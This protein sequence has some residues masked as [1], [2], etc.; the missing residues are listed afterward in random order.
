MKGLLLFLL[1]TTCTLNAASFYWVGGSGDWNDVTHWAA[2]SGGATLYANTPSPN[3]D[4]FIDENS[5][6]GPNQTIDLLD[7]DVQMRDLVITTSQAGATLTGGR[8]GMMSVYGNLQLGTNVSWGYEAPI[9]LRG[10]RPD[11]TVNTGGR[12]I[13][14][15]ITFSGAATSNWLVEADVTTDGVFRFQSGNLSFAPNTT[16]TARAASFSDD[17]S[18]DYTGLSLVV[19]QDVRLEMNA[20]DVPSLASCSVTI[21]ASSFVTLSVTGVPTV[22]LASIGYANS[23][24][25]T[26]LWLG[27][28]GTEIAADRIELAGNVEHRGDS[29]ATT[30]V[31]APGTIHQFRNEVTL[32]VT[33]ALEATAPC[34][35]PIQL[36]AGELASVNAPASATINA[37]GLFIENVTATGGADFTATESTGV[38]TVTGWNFTDTQPDRYWVGG[39]G[40]WDDP[41][42]WSLTSGGPAGACPPT[43]L[44]DV[45][46]DAASF[47][48]PGQTVTIPAGRFGARTMDWRGND[49]PANIFSARDAVLQLYG[50]LFLAENVTWGTERDGAELLF[51][52]G[53]TNKRVAGKG[54]TGRL[55]VS[56][57]GTTGEW[58]LIDS[59]PVSKNLTLISGAL[60]TNDQPISGGD[61]GM[62]R[63]GCNLDLTNSTVYIRDYGAFIL[64]ANTSVTL[65]GGSEGNTFNS[66]GATIISQN[67]NSAV[68]ITFEGDAANPNHLKALLGEGY[69]ALEARDFYAET[70]DLQLGGELLIDGRVDD[71]LL[72]GGSVYSFG[73]RHTRLLD[74]GRFV[75][76][77]D[78][79]NQAIL[80]GIDGP[81]T[82]TSPTAQTG[83]F[84]GIENIAAAGGPWGAVSSNDFGG[85]TGWNFTSSPTARTLYWVGNGGDWRDPTHWS[86]SSGGPGGEC[87]PG[88]L[89]DVVFDAASFSSPG[90]AVLLAPENSTEPVF[91]RTIET[92]GLVEPMSFQ[93][94]SMEA[95]GSAY[96]SS[97]VRFGE[98]SFLREVE[99][100]RF[101]GTGREAFFSE[102]VDF[103]KMTVGGGGQLDLLAPF[104]GGFLRVVNGTFRTND[105]DL[106]LFN[107]FSSAPRLDESAVATLDMGTTTA[108]LSGSGIAFSLGGNDRSLVPNDGA[109]IILTNDPLIY[110]NPYVEKLN[111]T[112]AEGT[113][114]HRIDLREPLG[115]TPAG[116][117]ARLG[118]VT[119]N[120]SVTISAS[121][122]A[123]TLLL[124]PGFTYAIDG[125]AD[126][127]I[128]DRLIAVGTACNPVAVEQT[129]GGAQPRINF[130]PGAVAEMDYVRLDRVDATGPGVYQAG[131]N[132]V[133]VND[134]STGWAFTTNAVVQS[135]DREFLGPDPTGCSPPVLV[136]AVPDDFVATYR[137]RGGSTRPEFTPPG[138][139]TYGLT[140]TFGED[141]CRVADQ[142]TIGQSDLALEAG[143][144]ID[145]CGKSTVELVVPDPS[146][147][148]YTWRVLDGAAVGTPTATAIT[149]AVPAVVELSQTV[150]G[151]TGTSRYNVTGGV[152]IEV[153]TLVSLCP[154]DSYTTERGTYTP[155]D[156]EVITEVYSEEGRCDSTRNITFAV[157][158]AA[159]AVQLVQQCVNRT[160]TISGQDYIASQDTLITVGLIG[161]ARCDNVQA[162]EVTVILPLR[163]TTILADYTAGDFTT[164]RQTY[165]FA[166]DTIIEERYTS[167]STGC[168]SLH[169]YV[170]SRRSVVAV[171]TEVSLCGPA[172]FAARSQTYFVTRDTIITERN[173]GPGGRDTLQTYQ[174]SVG[175]GVQ[176]G[177]TTAEVC[178]GAFITEERGYFITR[179]T[180]FSETYR[181][182]DGCDSIHTYVLSLSS[183]VMTTSTAVICGAAPFVTGRA[184]YFV[185]R[186][187]VIS[188][189]YRS[190][191]DCD[192][193]VNYSVTVANNEPVVGTVNV[194]DVDCFDPA[195]GT[196]TVIGTGEFSAAALT[197]NGLAIPFN[198]TA[199]GLAA[200]DYLLAITYPNGC[201]ENRGLQITSERR[202]IESFAPIYDECGVAS[203]PL[204]TGTIRVTR[205]TL[206]RDTIVTPTGCSEVT[207]YDVDLLEIP[208]LPALVTTTDVSCFGA[209][210]GTLSVINDY[211]F[212]RLEVNGVVVT[213]DSLLT[214]LPPGS[215]EVAAYYCDDLTEVSENLTVFIIEPEP[216]LVSLPDAPTVLSGERI[217][218][219]AEV[220]G[221]VGLPSFTYAVNDTSADAR[222][223]DCPTIDLGL[224]V[225]ARVAVTA[226]DA[227]GCVA[228]DSTLV[229]VVQQ[230]RA[231]LPTAFS[232]NGDGVN[233]RL[234]VYGAGTGAGVLQLLEVYDRWGG[235]V[236]HRENIPIGDPESGWGGDELPA[237]SY[238]V[239]YLIMWP[240]G[241][242]TNR[243]GAVNLL[244]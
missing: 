33:G 80:R 242:V 19:R 223:I 201:V 43:P 176:T 15:E 148:G 55:D 7:L 138:P 44:N 233:D 151:C 27:R 240:D 124:A 126:L 38:N 197:L 153:D 125:R 62:G 235:V 20:A 115:G 34:T 150:N 195:S 217:E 130:R 118:T 29:R 156:G 93:N 78:C 121:F 104:T 208:N 98:S 139:G 35:D 160:F 144:V 1:L 81:Y 122:R 203:V 59:L 158:A 166:G 183:S 41:T 209:A 177:N 149:V 76:R 220:S 2:T 30:Y 14:S 72:S 157:G 224:N 145:G 194:G 186:D 82:F 230:R 39:T 112:F 70:V 206:I 109:T 101:L 110:I 131:R 111:I 244:R 10:G 173:P 178:A 60:N 147:T 69:V 140:I 127:R 185:T 199:T 107:L 136:P 132:S 211:S 210:D 218:L 105:H 202:T 229:T 58:I 174:V 103:P 161:D 236:F 22:R 74:L 222:C 162:Y 232:P 17:G 227:G 237:G 56:F 191:S 213:A 36:L 28:N 143:R 61:I 32:S 83:E 170:I 9:V 188:E 212:Y 16:V 231:Y 184:S 169:T 205:D 117:R 52:G 49:D 234:T 133:N 85:A 57:N 84:L 99:E 40:A 141:S 221:G 116:Q 92:R 200:G 13:P 94:G 243:S 8:N 168:D 79:Q 180:S 128:R 216:L 77:S 135:L 204:S 48:A 113:R 123:D 142:I 106:R 137:W 108:W 114:D 21:D 154:G 102:A 155:E 24:P 175:D 192:S 97:L 225:S 179:D 171:S 26:V 182:A 219:V 226:T 4:V 51:R 129:G 64:D 66:A 50:S 100:I 86:L 172:P 53:G 214:D 71:L 96:F 164:P 67:V 5:F 167:S 91:C 239:N 12:L 189:T 193:V 46:F 37:N 181:A 241:V 190:V 54:K 18:V 159:G 95:Y 198:D 90:E 45:Y 196:I 165:T 68:E 3:D 47:T 89:D 134:A 238:V 120:S 73:G 6:S 11:A 25:S 63:S 42:H 207:I 215:Y 65:R 87:I 75:A 31:L 23:N 163:D 146:A 228:T 119:A 187:T 152:A 88:Q